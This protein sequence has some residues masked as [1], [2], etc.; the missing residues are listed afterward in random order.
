METI[1]HVIQDR[2]DQLRQALAVDFVGMALGTTHP[3][4]QKKEIRW[5]YASGNL[6]QRYEKIV[7]QIGHGFAGIVWRTGRQLLEQHL[8]QKTADELLEYPIAIAEEL[9]SVVVQPVMKGDEML[10]V[11][12]IGYRSVD[13]LTLRLADQLAEEAEG[14][15][16]VLEEEVN[17][18][19]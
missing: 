12:L 2:I 1:S 9:K 15:V 16:Q 19:N 5:R 6:S 7:L 10:A 18:F 14:F 8:E 13:Q 3:L 17:E 4:S 11:L